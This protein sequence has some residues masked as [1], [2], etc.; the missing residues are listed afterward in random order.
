M[1][2]AILLL[3]RF[4]IGGS[5]RFLS[6]A[7]MLRVFQ[8]ACVRAGIRVRHSE[9]FNPRPKLSLPL[10]RPV[11]VESDDELLCLHVIDEVDKARIHSELAAQLPE[12]CE[13]LSVDT[14]T[15]GVSFQ[16]RSAT[17]LL[18][19]NP[20]YLDKKMQTTVERLMASESLQVRRRMDAKG[21]RIKNVD[22]RVFLKSIKLDN[23]NIMVDCRISPAGSVR[24]NEIL[25]LLEL[26]EKTLSGPIR[27]TNVQWQ[28]N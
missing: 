14:A 2:K 13:L 24:I 20:Q 18:P 1:N 27:R 26:D 5:L 3:V 22:V 11:G 16:P 23:R 19:I 9:G 8:R 21:F 7:E 6:H 10:P 25:E 15:S 17:Y 28:R 4:K 12:G